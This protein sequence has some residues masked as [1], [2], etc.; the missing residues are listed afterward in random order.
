MQTVF[1]F[2]LK[3]TYKAVIYTKSMTWIVDRFILVRL[4]PR[5]KVGFE[6]NDVGFN[7]SD[8]IEPSCSI[9]DIHEE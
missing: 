1:G 9:K 2:L 6:F 8:Y 4:I 7:I 3:I 5:N